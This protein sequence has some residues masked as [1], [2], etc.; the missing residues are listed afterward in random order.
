VTGIGWLGR[1]ASGLNWSCSHL[2]ESSL[3][4]KTS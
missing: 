2:L 1:E 3:S 4:A